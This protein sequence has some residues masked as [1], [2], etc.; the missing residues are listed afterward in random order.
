MITKRATNQCQYPVVAKTRRKRLHWNAL[1]LLIAFLASAICF[2]QSVTTTKKKNTQD[3]KLA[4]TEWIGAVLSGAV[5]SKKEN[6]GF[7]LNADGTYS[8][9]PKSPQPMTTKWE[10]KGDLITLEYVIHGPSLKSFTV[11]R[12][13]VTESRD[14]GTGVLKGSLESRIEPPTGFINDV[15]LPA[16]FQFKKRPA[17]R[18][19]DPVVSR[20]KPPR[21]PNRAIRNENVSPALPVDGEI[22]YGAAWS[23]NGS[24]I[25]WG[26]RDDGGARINADHSFEHTFQLDELSFGDDVSPDDEDNSQFQRAQPERSDTRLQPDGSDQGNRMSA[27]AF[28][29]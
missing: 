18:L 6:F 3:E 25:A 7:T 4:K 17:Q 16:E 24:E 28:R 13:R 10:V 19:N 15:K 2:G 12:L 9:E 23:E 21:P 5:L 8:T 14:D 26:N 20:D 29:L 1:L 11:M 27:L 22:P